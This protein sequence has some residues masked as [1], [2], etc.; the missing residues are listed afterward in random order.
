MLVAIL[1]TLGPDPLPGNLRATVEQIRNFDLGI[2]VPVSF[3]SER[4][5]GLNKVFLTTV[6]KGRFLPISGW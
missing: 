2:N 3:T 1:E 6:E 4:H 5:Q